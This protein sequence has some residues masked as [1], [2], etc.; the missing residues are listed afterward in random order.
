MRTKL[1]TILALLSMSAALFAQEEWEP[2]TN[3][4]G[5]GVLEYNYFKDL[6]YYDRDYAFSLSEAG[7][8]ASYKPKEKLQLKAVFV[9]RPEYRFDQMLNEVYAEYSF[10][11]YFQLKGGRFLVPVSPMNTYYYAPVN[12]SATL[13]MLI[14]N[15]EFFPL[16]IDGLSVN[17]KIGEN[18]KVDYDL[19]FGGFR[20]ALWLKTGPLGLFA[21]EN[22]YFQRVINLDTLASNQS[23]A[24]DK[25]HAGGGAHIGFSYKE[26]VNIGL[27]TFRSNEVVTGSIPD[28]LTG[29]IVEYASVVKKKSYGISGTFKFSTVKIIGEYWNTD[30]KMDFLG[31]PLKMKYKGAFAELSNT[32]ANKFTPYIRYEYHEIPGNL[33]SID[34]YRYTGGINYKPMFE[35]TIKLE[36]MHY[37][38]GSLD[39]NGVVAAFIFSF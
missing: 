25:L 36:Y 32:F 13:P 26:F 39:L 35:T 4:T 23:N 29:E 18:F 6:Q 12:N 31:M 9:Y 24:N 28:W 3:I 16:N 5:Y 21:D 37:K 8:L 15:H 20:N 17:G 27:N 34:Y 1:F 2:Q 19:F 11:S 14:T 22:N 30:V 38:Y 10:N 33:N 7:I